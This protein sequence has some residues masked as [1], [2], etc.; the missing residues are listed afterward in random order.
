MTFELNVKCLWELPASSNH[1][2]IA[3]FNWMEVSVPIVTTAHSLR[4][5]QPENWIIPIK[6]R[7]EELANL[8]SALQE[9]TKF[10]KV[11]N[12]HTLAKHSVKKPIS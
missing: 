10:P 2:E 4:Q 9:F 12:T 5:L 8:I 6:P 1:L 7:T 11:K 3:K